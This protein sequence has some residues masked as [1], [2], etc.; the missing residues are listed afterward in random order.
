MPNAPQRIPSPAGWIRVE[1]GGSGPALPVLLMHG[2]A[3]NL[4]T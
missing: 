3:M 2:L 1:A 4:T